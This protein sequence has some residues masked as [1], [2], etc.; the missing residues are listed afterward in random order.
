VIGDGRQHAMPQGE[1]AEQLVRAKEC[2][3]PRK[4]FA[5]VLLAGLAYARYKEYDLEARHGRIAG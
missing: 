4:C 1:L 5:A 2:C 3:D